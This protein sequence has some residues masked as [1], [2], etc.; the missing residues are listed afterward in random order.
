MTR[1]AESLSGRSRDNNKLYNINSNIVRNVKL[2]SAK[3]FWKSDIFSF[4]IWKIAQQS[5]EDHDLLN[6]QIPRGYPS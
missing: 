1:N 4:L 6:L 2:I 3:E 5:I